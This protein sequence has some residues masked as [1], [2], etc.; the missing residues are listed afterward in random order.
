[1]QLRRGYSTGPTATGWRVAGPMVRVGTA[2]VLGIGLVVAPVAVNASAAAGV[3]TTAAAA[4]VGVRSGD[5]GSVRVPANRRRVVQVGTG[6]TGTVS[7]RIAFRPRSPGV[8][9]VRPVDRTAGA[10]VSLAARANRRV[11]QVIEL[12]VGADGRWW[13]RWKSR[14]AVKVNYVVKESGGGPSAGGE[15]GTGGG[16]SGAPGAPGGP[17]SGDIPLSGAGR[18]EIGTPTVTGVWV[19]PGSGSDSRSGASRSQA[20]RTV[21]E[22]WNRIPRNSTL[23]TGHRVQLVTGNYPA[24]VLPNYLED[25]WGTYNAPIIFNAADGP[26]TVRL[27]GDLNIYNTRFL[28]LVGINIERAG[29]TFHCELCSY[30]LL[31]NGVFD[32]QGAAHETIKVNQSDHFMIEDSEVSGAWDNA[33]DFVAVQYGHLRGNRIH[34]GGDWCAYAKGG[35]AYLVVADNEIYSCGTGGF[36]AGQGTGFE[37][38]TSPWL[39]FEAYDI[40]VFNNV[41]HDTEGAG[42][43]V[44]GGFNIL[45]A[46]NTLYRVGSRSH[47]VEFVF[48]MRGC[49]GNVAACAARN[50]LGGWGSPASEGEGWIP[51]NHVYFYNNVVENPMPFRSAW[52]QFA[53]YGPRVPPAG[54]NVPSPART[55]VDLRIAGNLI[56]NGP[57]TSVDPGV[58]SG[59]GCQDSNPTC[60]LAQLVSANSINLVEPLLVAPSTGDYRPTDGGVIRS[61]PAV[62]IPDFAWSDAPT[63]P[64]APAGT[65]SNAVPV[66]RAGESRTGWG[67]PGAY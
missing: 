17:A 44:N 7:V 66:N 33:I 65:A 39:H 26:G 6:M 52:S 63:T 19:D 29:D 49:D 27:T 58:G 4:A 2:C 47:A 21:T 59:S 20:L 61:T 3:P 24:D 45:M 46:Y 10:G 9:S 40:K 54:T 48:G 67:H 34:D 37:F 15:S 28:Y 22:A 32:G 42:L 25:R 57:G 62:E 43:G 12:P 55:D 31:R 18:F 16:G 41:I 13:L 5:S 14:R 51:N 35:S 38:M 50:A 23:A 11:A 36:T 60:N 30:V 53:I 8:L 1:M 56:W 64:S